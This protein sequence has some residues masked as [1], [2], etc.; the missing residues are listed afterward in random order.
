MMLVFGVVSKY[1]ATQRLIMFCPVCC[2]ADEAAAAAAD[3][4]HA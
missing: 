3:G 2:A 4:W 1:R